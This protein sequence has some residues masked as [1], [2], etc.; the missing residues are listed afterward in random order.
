MRLSHNVIHEIWNDDTGER[1][2]IGPDVDGL[3]LIEVR[4]LDAS[5]KAFQ[6]LTFTI[7]QADFL[8]DAI[9]RVAHDITA[10][11]EAEKLAKEE[12]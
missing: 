3:N 10:N 9:E 2:V 4:N 6:T 1:M 5:G 12:G 8:L 7:E 11:E